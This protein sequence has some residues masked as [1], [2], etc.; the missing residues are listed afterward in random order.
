MGILLFL[1]I[2]TILVVVIGHGI[3]AWNSPDTGPDPE[4]SEEDRQKEKRRLRRSAAGRA[5]GR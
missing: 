4:P 2:G 1:V 3:E 5:I